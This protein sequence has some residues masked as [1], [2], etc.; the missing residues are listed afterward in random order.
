MNVP[1]PI[2]AWLVGTACVVVCGMQ[3]VAES[4]GSMGAAAVSPAARSAP[5]I[6]V[7]GN[8]L[9]DGDGLPVR[10]LG[11]N[12]A[13]VEG[14][15]VDA[16]FQIGASDARPGDVFDLGPDSSAVPGQPPQPIEDFFST[17]ESWH[18]NA[19]RFMVN[20]MCWLGRP[21]SSANNPPVAPIPE[22]QNSAEQYRAA[23]RTFVT[24]LHRFGMAAVAVLGDNPCP[25]QWPSDSGTLY[26][27]PGSEFSPCDDSQQVMPDA[28]NAPDFWTSFADTFR[29][30]RS[31]VFELYNEPHTNSVRPVVDEWGCWLNG[32]DIPNEG[33]HAA[34]MQQLIDAI[35]ATGAKQ[36][37]LVPGTHYS[38]WVYRPEYGGGPAVG[39]IVDP[40]RPRD[41]LDPPQLAAANHMCDWTYDQ[42]DIGCPGGSTAQCWDN[43]LGPVA[44]EVPLVTTELGESDCDTSSAFM[45]RYMDWA[46]SQT[47]SR[48][49]VSYLG[50]TFNGDYNC[51]A[52]NS[53][54]ISDWQGT[55][56]VAGAALR[57]RLTND[58]GR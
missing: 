57:Q 25:Y 17:L 7:D 42:T 8:Q 5:T 14:A 44:A 50:W 20:E 22:A 2:V 48:A 10:L 31:M 41:T 21:P 27:P 39:W 18:V 34:G 53:T 43:V 3:L 35:R 9:V 38:Q 19:I 28:A 56:T 32:C 30:D 12:F 26:N 37:I 1:A 55:P 52:V 15:C 13:G 51:D 6:V 40:N 49:K 4:K 11:V 23:I 24:S 36:P 54:L 46:D 58:D 47:S 45:D 16:G 29:D 33:W